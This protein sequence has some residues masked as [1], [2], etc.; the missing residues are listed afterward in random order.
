[1]IGDLILKIKQC[2]CIH[3]Y[4]YQYHIDCYQGIYDV[5]K[6]VKCGRIKAR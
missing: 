2:F 5:Y 4:K 6:C 1:M 3:D